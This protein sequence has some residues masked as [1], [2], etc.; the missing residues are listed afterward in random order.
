MLKQTSIT[1]VILLI[2]VIT[3]F[4]Q[5]NTVLVWTTF[6][7]TELEWLNAKATEFNEM[8][9]DFTI[10][11]QAFADDDQLLATYNNNEGTEPALLHLTDDSTQVIMDLQITQPYSA[12]IG[13]AETIMDI[14]VHQSEWFDTITAHA[15]FSDTWMMIP[16]FSSTA[17]TYVNIDLLNEL[18]ASFAFVPQDL[19]TLELICEELQSAIED[20]SIDSCVVWDDNM[21]LFE[22]WLAQQNTAL[23]NNNNGRDIRATSF[24]LLSEASIANIEYMRYLIETGYA[25]DPSSIEDTA[26]QSFIDGRAPM[27][28]AD[29]TAILNADMAFEGDVLTSNV[30]F[31]WSGARLDTENLWLSANV[32]PE[33]AEAATAFALYLTAPENNVEWHQATGS[34]PLTQSAYD[35]LLE[36]EWAETNPEQINVLR[37]LTESIAET[38]TLYSVI[39]NSIEIR[40]ALR[41]GL[42][43]IILSDVDVASGLETTQDF[44]A[45]QLEAYNL[46]N[47]P[48]ID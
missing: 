38:S 7:A 34:L 3:S 14:P 15:T 32:E 31:G 29:N 40:D 28:F 46:S 43:Q 6:D 25:I 41:F 26:I 37:A 23:V 35:L 5:E 2:F 27:L 4:A 12:V 24:D 18:E 11:V 16:I 21:W 44:V 33:I 22:N 19:M 17:M 36:S 13:D 1:I 45:D 48:D 39:G 20:G 8:Q 10:E 30:D 9:S 42:N 47:A